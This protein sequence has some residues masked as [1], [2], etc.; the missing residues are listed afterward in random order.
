MSLLLHLLRLLAVPHMRPETTTKDQE[1]KWLD[2]WEEVDLLYHLSLHRHQGQS[3]VF[4]LSP[5]R[6]HGQA[7]F[8]TK[9]QHSALF[10]Y[11][12]KYTFPW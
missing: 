8:D 6:N 3:A 9:S 10:W 5:E 1:V 2:F 7:E 11:L 4:L 12:E